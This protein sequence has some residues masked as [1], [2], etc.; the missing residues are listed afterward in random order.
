MIITV[1]HEV[2]WLPNDVAE[3]LDQIMTAIQTLDSKV[4]SLAL[5]V[6]ETNE[7]QIRA[8]AE[9]VKAVREKLQ[10]SVNNQSQ[11]D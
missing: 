8:L 1:I 11:G 3:K 10:T 6:K 4:E 7:T 9:E 5:T 2:R